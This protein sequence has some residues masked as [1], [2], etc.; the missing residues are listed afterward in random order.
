MLICRYILTLSY[1]TGQRGED[2]MATEA[3][4]KSSKRYDK[5]NTRQV[6]LKL[7]VRTD[8]DI[9]GKLDSVGNK[10]GYIK[11]LILR[12]MGDGRC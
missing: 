5:A 3:R 6:M 10:Q 2:A 12:D 4:K 8:A 9:L 7:N 1:G 11:A